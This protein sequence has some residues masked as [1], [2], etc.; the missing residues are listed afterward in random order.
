MIKQG[1]RVRAHYTGRLTGRPEPFDLSVGRQ[2]L[3][4]TVG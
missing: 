2:P 1:S 3:E 4:F